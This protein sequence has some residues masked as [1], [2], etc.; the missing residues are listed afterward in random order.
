MI[1]KVLF[2]TPCVVTNHVESLGRS[3]PCSEPGLGGN[4]QLVGENV[5]Q[6]PMDPLVLMLAPCSMMDAKYDLWRPGVPF[7]NWVMDELDYDEFSG[8]CLMPSLT[9]PVCVHAPLISFNQSSSALVTLK[10]NTCLRRALMPVLLLILLICP[11]L[12]S[13]SMPMALMALLKS[14][15]LG[16]IQMS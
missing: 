11:S 13:L 8:T 6:V 2:L 14:I 7:T 16:A 3:C 4:C 9:I 10:W 1:F 15:L 12:S 5:P